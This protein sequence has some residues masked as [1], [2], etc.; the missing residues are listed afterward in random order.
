MTGGSG[1]DTP[2]GGADDDILYGGA[3]DDTLNGGNDDDV[4]H[5]QDGEDPL[6]GG[7][8]ADKFVLEDVTAFNDVDTIADFNSGDGDKLDIADI[9]D[10]FYSYGVDDITDF[11]LIT[12]DSTDSTVYIDQDGGADNFVAVAMILGVT[13]LTNEAALESGGVLVT[14]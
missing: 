8:G 2:V 7:S 6:Y 4:L 3:G 14:R 9:L 5:G 12:D 11:V 1:D 10:G 13:R